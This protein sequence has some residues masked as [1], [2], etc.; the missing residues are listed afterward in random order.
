MMVSAQGADHTTG[1]APKLNTRAM[2]LEEI[3]AAS[4]EAQ[5]FSAAHDSLGICLFGRSVN[6]F[7]TD[8]LAEA[9][10]DA[11]GISLTPDFF[12]ELGRETLIMEKEFNRRAGFGSEDNEL[13]NFFYEQ[14]LPPT[15]HVARFHHQD[16]AHI[17]DALLKT[18]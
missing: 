18:T 2:T 7:N 11:L 13:P 12:A 4:L 5:I 17:Y 15:N 16:V 8:F 6:N 14:A 10:R 3:V 1:N 9:I